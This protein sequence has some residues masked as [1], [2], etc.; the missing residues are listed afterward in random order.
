MTIDQAY[1]KVNAVAPG[2]PVSPLTLPEAAKAVRKMYRHLTG[3]KFP[4]AITETSGNRYTWLRG[5]TFRV[6]CEKGWTDLIHLF[7]HWYHRTTNGG[8]PHSKSH[9]R[10]ERKLRAWAIERG[11]LDGALKAEA[12]VERPASKSEAR[13]ER[14]ERRRAQVARLERKLKALS[15]RLKTARRSLRALER[16]A[17]KQEASYVGQGGED[18]QGVYRGD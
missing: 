5:T 8:R 11:W 12:K 9:A 14:I 4:Y 13:A 7:S 15:T 16:H 1:Q 2:G 18:V 3:R 6:N 17:M 10:I